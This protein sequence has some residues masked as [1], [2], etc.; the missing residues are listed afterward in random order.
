[1]PSKL[2]FLLFVSI[3]TCLSLNFKLLK[4]LRESLIFITSDGIMLIPFLKMWIIIPMSILVIIV[5]KYLQKRFS[6]YF[7]F[8]FFTLCFIA[9]CLFF[10]TILYPNRLDWSISWPTCWPTCWPTFWVPVQLQLMLQHWVISLFYVVADMW[11]TVFISVLFWNIAALVFSLS[12][13]KKY[14]PLFSLDIAGMF[15]VLVTLLSL[16]S[17]NNMTMLIIIVAFLQMFLMYLVS[18]QHQIIKPA[19]NNNAHTK[20]TKNHF[21]LLLGIIVF[22]YEFSDSFLDLMWKWNVSILYPSQVGYSQY[23]SNV[24]FWTGILGTL[25]CL[26]VAKPLAQKIRWRTLALIPPVAIAVFAFC[27]LFGVF[28]KS[29]IR[30]IVLLGVFLSVCMQIM[31]YTFFDNAKELALIVQEENMRFNAKAFADGLMTPC[32]KSSASLIQQIL[33]AIIINIQSAFP[34][35]CSIFVFLALLTWIYAVLKLDCY[36]EKKYGYFTSN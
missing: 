28:C 20:L 4:I 35:Y 12:E 31:K 30:T 1:M 3:M 23:M 16:H 36:V 22:A 15:V 33:F 2:Y 29:N 26:F 17:V 19:Q 10:I 14:Y 18:R 24:V 32:G 5:L 9:F 6:L 11:S 25:T 8:Q 27:F 21:M 34:I 7:I 13:A